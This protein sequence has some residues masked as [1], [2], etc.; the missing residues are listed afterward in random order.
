[1]YITRREKR[2]GKKETKD[3][4]KTIMHSSSRPNHEGTRLMFAS[5]TVSLLMWPYKARSGKQ[6][7]KRAETRSERRT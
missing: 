5:C 3:A 4:T 7:K 2:Q 6:G 1:M